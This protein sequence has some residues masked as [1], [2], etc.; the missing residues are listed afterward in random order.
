[1][2][3]IRLPGDC[4]KAANA[5]AFNKTTRR[6]DIIGAI[7]GCYIRLQKPPARG[8]DYINRKYY[9]S[10]LLQGI[11]NH[12][13]SFID[14]FVGVPGRVHDCR[15]LRMSPFFHQWQQL[16]GSFKHLGDSAYDA[17]DFPFIITPQKHPNAA[18][19]ARNLQ[20]CKGR[21]IVENAFGRL[22]CRWRP[23]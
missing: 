20:L 14:I 12:T 16:M 7:D 15:M 21:V 4:E 19:A 18:E 9:C 17:N 23:C 13:G 22:K 8:M 2:D 5:T 10:I 6:C 3:H 11:V 1:M